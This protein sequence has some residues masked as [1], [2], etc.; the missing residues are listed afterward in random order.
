M[1]SSSGPNVW[2]ALPNASPA[3]IPSHH[4]LDHRALS[5]RSVAQVSTFPP[6][7]CGLA[8]FAAATGK[9]LHLA[10]PG[11]TLPM[12][13]VS[14]SAA[15]TAR[16]AARSEVAVPWVLSDVDSLV[17]VADEINR[18]QCLVLEHEFGI[19]GPN[20]GL[21][22][23]DL[24]DKVTVPVIAFL[25]T[26]LSNPSPGQRHVMI[27]LA[28]RCSRLV[29]MSE[30]ARRRLLDNYPV[31]PDQVDV[32]P[33]GAQAVPFVEPLRLDRV[34]VLLTWGL[35]GPGKG[36][37]RSIRAVAQLQGRGIDVEYR[38]VG[39][40]H[41]NVVLREG[42]RYRE[43]LQVLANDLGVGDRVLFDSSYRSVPDLVPV[44]QD[45]DIVIL[46]YDS[47]DQVTSGVLVEA[48]A[49]GKIIVATSFPHAVEAL[50][51]GAGF[52]VD[53]DDENGMANVVTWLIQHPEQA[54]RVSRIAL[55]KGSSMLWDAVG[56]SLAS[57]VERVVGVRTPI[58]ASA[59][60]LV[61]A[62]I[63]EPVRA[64]RS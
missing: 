51:N 57:L 10:R 60:D 45:A 9:A 42:E 15:E 2:F 56:E 63:R 25:H 35:V 53:H 33:H 8:T 43:S 13:A 19:F 22:A 41:P 48:L 64:V 26:V 27:E 7:Q 38:I 4:R 11:W 58:A 21:L 12:V 54:R 1:Q 17:A 5:V 46:P 23:I 3:P 18:C 47:R 14:E 31:S 55:R 44:V 49:G 28:N 34:P 39:E 40:T 52:V 30:S 6:R 62:S 32:I 37:E 36:L 50:A 61:T 29:V 24:L 16:L 59:S 20:D